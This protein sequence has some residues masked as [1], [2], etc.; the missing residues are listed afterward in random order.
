MSLTRTYSRATLS[1]G[2]G[3]AAMILMAGCSSD[4]A[5][6][7]PNSTA[8]SSAK[9]A[10]STSGPTG[11]GTTAAPAAGTPS[12]GS[13]GASGGG[14]ASGASLTIDGQPVNLPS[15]VAVCTTASG[16][17]RV[18]LGGSAAGLVIVMSDGNPPEVHQLTFGGTSRATIMY[19]AS[20]GIGSATATK[21]G[22][23]YTVKGEG[24]SLDIKNRSKPSLKSFE[25]EFT[26]K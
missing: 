11:G 15:T 24:M 10:T 7:V 16:E 3:L 20:A 12:E 26:C 22:T 18:A 4:P 2:T 17:T 5:A 19:G 8:P 9:A 6:S 23:S 13:G 25:V 1:V 14:G 21:N